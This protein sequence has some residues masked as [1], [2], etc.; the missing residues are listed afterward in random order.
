MTEFLLDFDQVA[1]AGRSSRHRPTF[2]A[3]QLEQAIPNMREAALVRERQRFHHD[4]WYLPLYDAYVR[5]WLKRVI[6]SVPPVISVGGIEV[7]CSKTVSQEEVADWVLHYNSG[8]FTQ[9]VL[10]QQFDELEQGTRQ[11]SYGKEHERAPR[12]AALRQLL[13][14]EVPDD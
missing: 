12:L 7:E 4:Q 13:G 10:Q 2:P 1:L 9:G 5:T 8:Y 3:R 11:F 14:K 6:F